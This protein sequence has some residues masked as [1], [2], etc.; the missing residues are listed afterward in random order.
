MT[1]AELS[2]LDPLM[3][4]TLKNGLVVKW[5]YENDKTV[6][7]DSSMSCE[8]T[9]MFYLDNRT[10]RDQYS[11][12]ED[13]T[14]MSHFDETTLSTWMYCLQPHLLEDGSIRVVPHACSARL[15]KAQT[16]VMLI[17]MACLLLTITAYLLVKKL[18]N[19]HGKCFICYMACLFMGYL[20]LLF[21]IWGLSQDFC[22]TSG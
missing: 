15:K 3:N 16:V 22:M 14:I 17:S 10:E 2:E 13:G 11:L 20:F 18:R 12:F 8:T 21:D 4:V 9:E 5:H 7:W 19:L 6:H 1:Q